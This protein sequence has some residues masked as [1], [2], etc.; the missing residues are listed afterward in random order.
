MGAGDGVPVGSGFGEAGCTMNR[1]RWVRVPE[2]ANLK[3]SV[4]V[5]IDLGGGFGQR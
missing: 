1:P 5:P 3:V 4:W 2:G